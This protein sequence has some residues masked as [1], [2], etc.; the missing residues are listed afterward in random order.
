MA[1]LGTVFFVTIFF[2]A[3]PLAGCLEDG[4]SENKKIEAEELIEV[5]NPCSMPSE[6]ITQSMITIQAHGVDRYFRL[7]VPSSEIGV[8]LPIVLA[9]H[10]GGGAEED[11]PQQE[12]FDALAEQEK[13]IMAYVISEEGRTES[14][15]EWF[16]NSAA[17]SRDDNVFSE[18]IVDELSK[19]YCIDEDRCM[20]SVIH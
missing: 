13:F 17:T 12:E 19:S 5:D 6:P 20:Q 7:T 8:K 9:F 1:R 3:L 14:E 10:G 15:G 4:V 18:A 16:L 11:F 2:L